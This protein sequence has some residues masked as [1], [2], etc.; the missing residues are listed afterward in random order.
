MQGK[1]ARIRN[2]RNIVYCFL[3]DA[4]ETLF[5][6]RVQN[7]NL[8]F[9]DMKQSFDLTDKN[10]ALTHALNNETWNA[11]VALGAASHGA[12]QNYY[13]YST[14][15]LNTSSNSSSEAET[16]NATE[17]AGVGAVTTAVNATIAVSMQKYLV[18]FVLT[19]NP[20]SVWS[21]DKIY[22]PMFN[23]SSVGA[24]IVL[25]DTFSVADDSLANAKSLFWNRR[26]GTEVRDH[27]ESKP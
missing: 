15:T 13:W 4:V 9:A 7:A 26:Y 27:F 16:T 12:D 24:Q 25:N 2:I 18:S 6:G 21:E 14:Y 23:E 3:D 10:I 8:R 22:W 20:N 5:Q 17:A 11:Q 1:T 19:G